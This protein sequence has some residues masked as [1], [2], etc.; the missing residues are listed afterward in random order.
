MIDHSPIDLAFQCAK[1]RSLPSSVINLPRILRSVT[2]HSFSF[3]G[4]L[5]SIAIGETGL[6]YRNRS[7]S[8]PRSELEPSSREKVL[9]LLLEPF[10][11]PT[12]E[13]QAECCQ[14]EYRT[15]NPQSSRSHRFFEF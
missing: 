15:C 5:V 6:M 8:F 12:G 4:D 14:L 9:G 7:M 1:S 2:P 10:L 11:H 13:Q 3:D